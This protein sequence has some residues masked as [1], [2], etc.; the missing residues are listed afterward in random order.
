MRSFPWSHVFALP[1]T[2]S[3]KVCLFVCPKVKRRPINP[4]YDS[5]EPAGKSSPA[6]KFEERN[7]YQFCWAKNS[8]IDLRKDESSRVIKISDTDTLRRL[9]SDT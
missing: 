3:S 1:L 5:V 6:K 7:H 2:F 9:A 8:T 4:P